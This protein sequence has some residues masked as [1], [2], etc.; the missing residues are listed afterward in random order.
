MNGRG[1]RV[2]CGASTEERET[3]VYLTKDTDAFEITQRLRKIK[4]A[5]VLG[6]NEAAWCKK[7]GGAKEGKY[8]T[9]FV[10]GSVRGIEEN[11]VEKS[12]F[13]KVLRSE[14]LEAPQRVELENSCASLDAEGIEIL[15]NESGSGRMI[16]DEHGF[17]GTATEGFDADCTRASE[18]VEEATAGDAFSEDIE[19]CLTEAVAGRTKGEALEAFE[20]AAAKCPGDDAHDR[21]DG[22][23]PT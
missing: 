7:R 21:F 18:D 5:A 2:Y 16:L 4:G 10:G 15:L 6:D 11:D 22:P 3:R 20:L 13:G 8:A 9:V 23:Q 14:A 17:G 1:I 19:E 12:A